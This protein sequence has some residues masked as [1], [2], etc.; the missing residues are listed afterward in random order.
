VYKFGLCEG[1]RS[2]AIEAFAIV[3]YGAIDL[4]WS[5]MSVVVRRCVVRLMGVCMED[6]MKIMPFD[7]VII[8]KVVLE[9]F[10]NLKVESWS[11]FRDFATSRFKKNGLRDKH[12]AL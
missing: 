4:L 5:K 6:V 12:N 9:S 3:G 2:T 10:L 8:H 7:D 1:R 11:G